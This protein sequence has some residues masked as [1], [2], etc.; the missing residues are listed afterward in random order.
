MENNAHM[1]RKVLV[2]PM[3]VVCAYVPFPRSTWIHPHVP[4]D[5]FD[6]VCQD[7][8]LRSKQTEAELDEAVC[9]SRRQ[10]Q[11]NVESVSQCMRPRYK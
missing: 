11:D 10:Q 9:A 8:L 6:H 7:I 2:T 1:E 5:D 3:R 4:A